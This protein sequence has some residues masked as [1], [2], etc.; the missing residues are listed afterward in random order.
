MLDASGKDQKGSYMS[1]PGE[2]NEPIAVIG[3][4]CR[5]PGVKGPVQLWENVLAR[6]SEF[7][8][9]PEKRLPAS[10]YFHEDK[11]T[12]DKTYGR[13]AAVLDGFVFDWAQRRIPEKSYL[14]TDIA[15]WLA[16]EVAIAALSDA[17]YD[18]E[19]IPNDKTGVIVGNTLTGEQ[20]RSNTLRLRW[21]Y[22]RRTLLAACKE[23][24][25]T[26]AATL[27]L[28][29]VMEDV[30]KSAFPAVTEDTLAGGLSNTIG[31]RVCNYL[32]AH[33]GGYTVDGA[34]SSSLLAVCTAAS[35]L[36]TG[37]L[38]LALAGGVDISLDP[39]ELVG[40]AKTGALTAGDM[41]VYDKKASGF[42]PGEGCGF[43]VLK[44]LTDAQAAGDKIYAIIRGWGIS[45][46]GKGGITTPSRSGQ[47]MA[48]RRAY[49]GAGFSPQML[50]FVEGHGTGTP[51]GDKTELEALSSVVGTEK[52]E[53]K[54]TCGIT[55]FKSIMGHTKAAAGVGAFIKAVIAAN[56]RVIPPTAGCTEPSDVFHSSAK[57]LYPVLLGQV[58]D[59]NKK[60]RA[61]VSAMGFG[62]INTHV[63]IESGPR[64]IEALAPGMDERALLVSNQESEVFVFGADSI[65]DLAVHIALVS[66]D[67]G[68]ISHGELVDL[69]KNLAE[70]LSATRTVRAAVIAGTPDQ[71]V[72]GLQ[73]LSGALRENQPPV[74]QLWR[75]A[76]GNAMVSNK[77]RKQRFAFVFPGQGSQQLLMARSLAERYVWAR[78]LV[79]DAD[80]WTKDMVGESI[81]S[82][83]FPDAGKLPDV[84]EL[85]AWTQRLADTQNAQPAICLASAIYCEYLQQLG[86]Q[87][88]V[89]GGHSLGELT[90]FYAAGAMDFET[91]IKFATFR[92]K[93]MKSPDGKP[94]AM[95]FL[96]CSSIDAEKLIAPAQGYVTLANIN[97]PKQTVVSGDAAAIDE[98]LERALAA[99]INAGRLPVSNAFH[100]R[101]VAPAAEKIK[102]TE[103]LPEK[104]RDFT[105]RL[106][107]CM[108]GKEV[109]E[110][111]NPREYFSHQV[112]ARVD[113]IGLT[114]KL[115]QYADLVIEVGPGGVLSRLFQETHGNE[116]ILCL[117]TASRANSDRDLNSVL[118]T[119]FAYGADINWTVAYAG[120]LARPYVSPKVREFFVNPCEN[121]LTLR[122]LKIA[123]V[124]IDRRAG[125]A[126]ATTMTHQSSPAP[127]AQEASLDS[128]ILDVAQ[129][130]T[131][132]P[133][134]TIPLTSRL[135][136][137]LNLD[138]I[139][140]TEL[141]I[142]AAR[143]V[144]V[145][146]MPDTA[147]FANATLG[148][149]AQAL[150][151]ARGQGRGTT[152]PPPADTRVADGMDIKEIGQLV[153]DVAQKH[154]GFP[155][156][157]IPLTSRLLDDLNLDSI[158]ATELVIEAA[159]RVGVQAMPDTARFANATLGEIAQALID[160]R[161]NGPQS[162][163]TEATQAAVSI[164]AATPVAA[165]L[166]MGIANDGVNRPTW[167]RD[168]IVQRRP[169]VLAHVDPI[170]WQGKRVLIV[171]EDSERQL[172]VALKNRL[173]VH[174][175]LVNDTSYQDIAQQADANIKYAFSIAILPRQNTNQTDVRGLVTSMMRRVRGICIPPLLPSSGT[176][177]C[178]AYVQFV[179][180]DDTAM[181]TMS[182]ESACA[183]A[184]ARS[185][186]L[187]KTD[188]RV[189]VVDLASTMPDAAA[190]LCIQQE[191]EGNDRF[192]MA[193][194]TAPD[195]RYVEESVPSIPSGYAQR[196]YAWSSND[197][198]MV[199]GGAKGVTAECA[200][201]V[202][203]STGVRLALVGSS[204]ATSD[205]IVRS[206]QRFRAKGLSCQYYA[207]DITDAKAVRDLV[208]T[209]RVELGPV[210]GVIHGAGANVPR[211][212]QQASLD[213][214]YREIAP[215]LVG[216]CNLFQALDKAAPKLF[217]AMTSIIGV[218]GMVGN[219]WYA[220]S[221]ESLKL[222][223]RDFAAKHEGTQ[224]LAVAFSV[225]D[226]VGMGARLGSI[227]RLA[228]MGIRAIPVDDGVRHFM[229]LFNGDPGTD[230]VVVTARLG[231][232]DT[233]T[234][235]VLPDKHALR[236]IEQ[237]DY[238]EPGVELRA[239]CHLT[240]ERD[241]YLQDHVYQGSY[242]FPTV[243][244]LEAMT[245]AAAYVLGNPDIE[246]VRID[247]IVLERPI[248]AHAVDGVTIGIIAEV[249][250]GVVNGEQSVRVGI[251]T[252]RSGYT[253]DHFA[254]T[255]VFGE[256]VSGGHQSLD[257]SSMLDIVPR[258]DL[259]GGL[260]FQ[261]RRFQRMEAIH[262]LDAKSCT[263]RSY[264]K[265]GS[266]LVSDSFEGS[267]SG[268]LLLG[269]AF[270]RDMLLQSIQ[271]TIPQHICLPIG[272]SRIERFRP[273]TKRIDN[274]IRYVL[275][276]LQR[277][278]GRDYIGKVMAC[279]EDGNLRESISG[280]RVR[281]V[282]E[283][284]DNPTAAE[285]ANPEHRDEEQLKMALLYAS[286][287]LDTRPVVVALGHIPN[288]RRVPRDQRKRL[289]HPVVKRAL[290]ENFKNSKATELDFAIT[291]KPSGKPVLAG[292]NVKDIDLSISHDDTY[293]M[294]VVGDTGQGCDI[295]PIVRRDAQDWVGLIGEHRMGIADELVK[296]GD[297]FDIAATRVWSAL[298]AVN[299]KYNKADPV[300]RFEKRLDNDAV[301]LHASHKSGNEWV[302]TLPVVF[303][304]R[305]ARMI[306]VC[307]QKN[308]ETGEPNTMVYAKDSE[309][310]E[311]L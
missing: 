219:A 166:T 40:F 60:M 207:C 34:C 185:L 98:V 7:R 286:R 100:S 223:L 292:K 21:P 153:L 204:P 71:L 239:R 127:A 151:A 271:L 101:L 211:T 10:G 303:T 275:V 122:S 92:G 195:S 135:L 124:A 264:I 87:P 142:E 57:S 132:F 212:I 140:A 297:T 95:A 246:V 288:L 171:A 149:I 85:E 233:W 105:A 146:A 300:L 235:R 136:D 133:A 237:V 32:D 108:D 200:L 53:A 117:P 62:G 112:T 8:L 49:S 61:G 213:E 199:T 15:Q 141:V 279:D 310:E 18:R 193:G 130:H 236:F 205:D 30:Y 1:S 67:A 63:A 225:W 88:S 243:F 9:I 282:K 79:A 26:D 25:M 222:M 167:V 249:R 110:G 144:G 220:F 231:G 281:I 13:R 113:F 177:D 36:A 209:I 97:S 74:G 291:V 51:V 75:N 252:E 152:P 183:K 5:Y 24:G 267:T 28:E 278:E 299:K 186:H 289:Q 250:D 311:V 99:E 3:I 125:D 203:Q 170:G 11:K 187:E 2:M 22:V 276:D 254:A 232:L 266:E 277:R 242:L 120:R 214:A 295:E 70:N 269:D 290:L 229:Q 189:R 190:A 160:A 139:K 263:I 104:A 179:Q 241:L 54:R 38:D 163:A 114:E 107:S 217:V 198:I 102:T 4:G 257:L 6:R 258:T 307:V 226:E 118:A 245:Q 19:T 172:A 48:I 265:D 33:G 27:A 50:D 14:S 77:M 208:E 175:A 68:F 240:L 123:D 294:C 12:P 215:K 91:L 41:T 273:E 29:S 256:P 268:R 154:T 255:L 81:S 296:M 230:E 188:M 178:V 44:R 201:A 72:R 174:G 173:V 155:A 216:A 47:A 121:D 37:Q 147:R 248:V 253:V 31:G 309:K 191:L 270:F 73:D 169:Q 244:G 227:D 17:G 293:L 128:V 283:N 134:S 287:E 221:N 164:G 52:T 39:F 78:K 168:F 119:A 43:V 238:V 106:V 83:L 86:L 143:R 158:K 182:A 194:Y 45:S 42:I 184:F 82:V 69:A 90:A 251:R 126:P 138:S 96:R 304:R 137:D 94:G 234:T 306:A 301:L 165:A 64:P 116:G 66:E 162:S 176:D 16:L 59:R 148:E 192:S 111:V 259:Y 305:P 46:D 197:V 180:G 150:G 103:L 261:G 131:G 247:D 35:Q 55:S 218:T 298:E 228:K 58:V 262:A 161:S 206:L 145:Q 181:H 93:V 260:L 89:I 23:N 202:G 109:T 224:A 159:R 65:A 129:K 280:Y 196:P 272:I 285:L 302:L 115:K 308:S 84:P 156:S 76:A 210:T 20:T 284:S 56:R 157:T 80:V 274:G